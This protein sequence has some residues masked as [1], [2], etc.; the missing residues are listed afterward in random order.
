MPSNHPSLSSA[1]FDQPSAV[2]SLSAHP[3]NQPSNQP[4]TLPTMLP[5]MRPSL[6]GQPSMQPSMTPSLSGQPSVSLEPTLAPS[7]CTNFIMVNEN[8]QDP[9]TLPNDFFLSIRLPTLVLHQD[10][11]LRANV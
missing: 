1:P 5:S 3:S 6:S 11:I 8:T 2:P 10:L 7:S 9:G 4:S